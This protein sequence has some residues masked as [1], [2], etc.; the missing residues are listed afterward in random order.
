[1]AACGSDVTGPGGGTSRVVTMAIT[2]GFGR[3]LSTGDSLRFTATAR[4]EDGSTQPVAPAWTV[5][6]PEIATIGSD[7]LVIARS[8][9][10]VGVGASLDGVSASAAL[11]IDSDTIPPVLADVFVD[12]TWVNIF[13]RPGVIGLR[14]EFD[15]D[16]SGTVSSIA[17]FEGPLGAGITGVVTLTALPPDSL[18]ALGDSTFTRTVFAGFLQIPANVGVGLWTLTDLRVDD[19]ARNSAQWGADALEDLGFVVEVQAVL[20][21][22]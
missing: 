18:A 2:P 14:A 20:T 5:S 7:G 13:Q 12:R 15:D 11:L 8:D 19:R 4:Y 6:D 1:M 21:G 9:G 22:G 16:G 17:V 10:F 3:L